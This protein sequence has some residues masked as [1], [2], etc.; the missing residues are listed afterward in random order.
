[1]DRPL[2]LL[3][4]EVLERVDPKLPR[5]RVERHRE[6]PTPGIPME[7]TVVPPRY[8]AGLEEVAMSITRNVNVASEWSP[9]AALVLRRSIALAGNRPIDIATLVNALDADVSATAAPSMRLDLNAYGVLRAADDLR[10]RSDRSVINLVD[11]VAALADAAF[12]HPDPDLGGL[13]QALTER[14]LVLTGGSHRAAPG[15]VAI[16][17]VFSQTPS[18]LV[19]R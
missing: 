10:S 2:P 5:G 8:C 15:V 9:A 6:E 1:L 3:V 16:A 13:R 18:T 14:L 11:L 19:S 17:D 4:D 7:V 12:T